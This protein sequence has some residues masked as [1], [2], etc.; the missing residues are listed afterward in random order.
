LSPLLPRLDVTYSSGLFGG[1]LD[2]ST[3]RWG[4]RGDATA[5][6]TWVLHNFG[7][8]DIARVRVQ[9]AVTNQAMAHV[10]EIQAQI[11]QEVASAAKSVG[12][13]S[14]QLSDDQDGVRQAEEMWLRLERAEFGVANG[15]VGHLEVLEPLT[16]L[17]QLQL[18][19]TAYLDDVIAYDRAEFQLYWALGKPPLCAL[20]QAT[21]LPTQTPVRPSEAEMAKPHASPVS[22]PLPQPRPLSR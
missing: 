16:A 14:R 13:I 9:R 21:A 4:G 7:L 3:I 10:L 20:P 1:G 15:R 5:E 8:G 22:Q 12:T 18:A 17:D 6:A 11:G 19:R 2:D